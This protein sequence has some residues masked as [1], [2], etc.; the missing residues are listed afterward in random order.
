MGLS[1]YP[2]YQTVDVSDYEDWLDNTL[3]VSTVEWT[4][5]RPSE[6]TYLQQIKRYFPETY[7]NYVEEW[8]NWN[9]LP[10][11]Q[12]ATTPEPGKTFYERDIAGTDP[13]ARQYYCETMNPRDPAYRL[14]A[15]EV[16][17]RQPSGQTTLETV[18]IPRLI[19]KIAE[20]AG[21]SLREDL[22]PSATGSKYDANG[23]LAS[24]KLTAVVAIAPK[25]FQGVVNL[26]EVTLPAVTKYIGDEAFQGATSIT[27]LS[28][29]GIQAI[30]NRTFEGCTSIEQMNIMSS[31]QYIGAEAFKSSGISE[32]VFASSLQ[33][34]GPGAFSDCPQLTTIE[35]LN[36]SRSYFKIGKY[37]FFNCPVLQNF[38]WN[39]ANDAVTDGAFAFSSTTQGVMDNFA[40]PS[41]TASTA[42][43]RL[44]DYIFANRTGLKTVT[45]PKVEVEN[46]DHSQDKSIPQYTFLNCYNLD[47]VEFPA[48]SNCMAM[49]DMSFPI[50]LFNE[51]VN[52]QF[53]VKGPKYKKGDNRNPAECRTSTW[54]AQCIGLTAIPYMFTDTDGKA[55]YEICQDGK[56]L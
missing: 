47:W 2:T 8:N 26:R 49:A 22:D 6:G 7:E 17:T 25:A 28:G 31:L 18:Y 4:L 52:E 3:K 54:Y 38:D 24:E 19:K 35:V 41:G 43:I 10:D 20:E 16:P 12:K 39:T 5:Q 56:L 53:Y 13:N 51:V 1:V 21:E 40:F 55:Y 36:S 23:F 50:D 34:V 11:D 14:V 27:Q 9:R 37:A 30:G 44:G 15:C 42:E 32:I 48:D 46:M 45:M 29:E 33:E